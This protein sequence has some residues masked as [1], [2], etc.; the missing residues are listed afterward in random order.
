MRSCR[1]SSLGFSLR[2]PTYHVSEQ[3][4]GGRP[5]HI[6][7]RDEAGEDET[8]IV[9]DIQ[10]EWESYPGGCEDWATAMKVYPLNLLALMAEPIL[11][12]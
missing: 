12:G 6:I 5:S 7:T 2:N 11:E 1:F 9:K 10:H 3:A 4:A 8:S